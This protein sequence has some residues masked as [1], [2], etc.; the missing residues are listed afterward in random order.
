MLS[1]PSDLITRARGWHFEGHLGDFVFG[2]VFLLPGLV[3]LP[4]AKP[5]IAYSTAAIAFAGLSA[6][7]HP[8]SLRHNGVLLMFLIFWY[9]AG[10]DYPA[11][12][13]LQRSGW[14]LRLARARTTVTA[15]AFAC[16]IPAT[17][18]AALGEF[19]SDF[20]TGYRVAS[21]LVRERAPLVSDPNAN[22]C[23]SVVHSPLV[24]RVPPLGHPR[25]HRRLR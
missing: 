21:W 2:L 5:L 19:S 22:L 4:S 3:A 6:F 25:E 20:S 18:L 11:F 12:R 13:V 1:P 10:K 16:T 15:L 23:A 24:H 9:V 14:F 7:K 17:V 8:T